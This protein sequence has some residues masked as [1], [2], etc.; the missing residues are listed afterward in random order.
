MLWK[1]FMN[2]HGSKDKSGIT[3]LNTRSAQ[4]EG[5]RARFKVL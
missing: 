1:H 4:L 3:G 2:N 5:W